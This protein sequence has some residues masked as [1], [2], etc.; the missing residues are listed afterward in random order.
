MLYMPSDTTIYDPLMLRNFGRLVL[1]CIEADFM[2]VLI[3]VILRVL[4]TYSSRQK[5]RRVLL[6]RRAA[7]MRQANG[8]PAVPRAGRPREAAGAAG[9]Q[10]GKLYK[11]RSR[12]YGSRFLQPNIRWKAL[13]ESTA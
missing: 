13:A 12:L 6:L 7:P 1:R 4:I 11:A 10:R 3:S 8:F 2:K 9:D 5:L